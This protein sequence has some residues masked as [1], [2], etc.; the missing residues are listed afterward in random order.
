MVTGMQEGNLIV[1]FFVS[2]NEAIV[3]KATI[4]SLQKR[5]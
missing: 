3:L 4:F 1:S 5:F 2:W